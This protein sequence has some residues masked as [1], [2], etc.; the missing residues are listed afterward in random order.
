M[1]ISHKY[2]LIYLRSP[3]TG[4]SSLSEFFIKNIPDPNALYTPVED[5]RIPGT[6]SPHLIAK[7]S[8]N[9]KFYHFTIE[10]L[11]K[12]GL[13]TQEQAE[14][15]MV[16]SVLRDP[17]DR[18]KSFF[19]FYGKWKGQGKT[20]TLNHYKQWAPNGYFHGEP[21][22][23]IKQTDFLKLGDK[24]IGNFWLYEDLNHKLTELMN[25]LRIEIK[26]PLPSHKSNFRKVREN[27]VTFDSEIMDKMLE[28]FAPD[29]EMYNELVGK[30]DVGY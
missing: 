8:A 23:A 30:S 4:S 27:E 26:H 19:Y 9:Y 18:Q 20:L 13:I 5:S 14:N 15:Y 3:K 25:F 10:D 16:I 6:I 28:V 12:E 22:S 11:I 21:N 7:Y 29:F 24:Y 2:K 17:V 1:Y